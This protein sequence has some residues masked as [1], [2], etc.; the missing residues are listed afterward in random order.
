MKHE[1]GQ[2]EILLKH[3]DEMPMVAS[4]YVQNFIDNYP[5]SDPKSF[6]QL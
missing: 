4:Q 1:F 3:V 2:R 5:K 6:L